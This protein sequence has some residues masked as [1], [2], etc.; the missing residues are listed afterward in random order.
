MMLVIIVLLL[1]IIIPHRGWLSAQMMP[2]VK[3]IFDFSDAKLHRQTA[4]FLPASTVA[5]VDDLYLHVD[6]KELQKLAYMREQALND[7]SKKK[8]DYVNAKIEQEQDIHGVKIRLKGD[9]TLH[10]SHETNWSFR[11]KMKGEKTLYG[12]K[13]FS[14]QKPV[15]KNYIYE[16]LFHKA[17]ERE[18]ILSLQYK[19]VN[20]HLNGTNLGVYA[21]EEHFGKRLL[22]RQQRREGPIVRFLEEFAM[23]GYRAGSQIAPFKGGD[24]T[25]ETYGHQ[26]QAAI[27]LLDAFRQGDLSAGEVFDVEK[28]ALYFAISDL[29]G[30]QHG[31]VAK[32]VRFY[33]NPINARLEP[34]GFDGHHGAVDRIIIAA[35]ASVDPR[36]AWLYTDYSSWFELLFNNH[37]NFNK[38]FFEAYISALDKVSAPDYLPSMLS[39][40]RAQIENNLAII[41]KDFPLAADHIMKVGPDMFV[42]DTGGF[43]DRQRYIRGVLAEKP[44][45]QAFAQAHPNELRIAFANTF[46]LPVEIESV[47][48]GRSTLVPLDQAQ[49]LPAEHVSDSPLDAP[50]MREFS[51]K[52]PND[53]SQDE[54]KSAEDLVVTY[55]MVGSQKTFETEVLPFPYDYQKGE[56]TRIMRSSGTHIDFPFIEVHDAEKKIVIAGG[57]HR[58]QSDLVFPEGYTVV[59]GPGVL[60]DLCDSAMILS[61]SPVQFLGSEDSPVII[62]SSD[63]TGQGLSLILK[64][65]AKQVS[66]IDHVIF[67]NLTNPKKDKWSVTGAVMFYQARVDISNSSFMS[68]QS[69]DCLNLVRSEFRMS[70]TSFA[71]TFSDALDLDFSNGS[72]SDCEFIASGN[73]AID[74]S[75]SIVTISDVTIDGVGDKAISVGEKSSAKASNIL[76]NKAEIAVTCKDQSELTI[77]NCQITNSRIGVTA[78]QK[79]PEFGPG[80]I[81]ATNLTQKDSEVPYMIEKRSTLTVDGESVPS[82]YKK[83]KDLLYGA[84]YGKSSK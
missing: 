69:E 7:R 15:T 50:S 30:M 62:E 18:D 63:G 47:T 56:E 37:S 53:Y 55:R 42:F 61:K 71:N 52:W 73:D 79:K 54:T 10:F 25:T 26:L 48:A 40:L 67:K 72:I 33:Y 75:G 24:N 4:E 19:F 23:G 13:Y 32:S 77:D 60:L 39:E 22:E 70:N 58:I 84:Q 8:F 1:A 6:Y 21:L 36:C 34:I 27:D 43:Y 31:V 68:N 65:S 66:I 38:E 81:V 29:L 9:R 51:F 20:L 59:A 46:R 2:V 44:Q 16:W 76:V 45:I 35:E 41:H 17:L 5:E 64:S 80:S 14:L 82:D 78:Y 74:L 28:L 12:M 49:I 11:V 3:Q 57:V 83:V